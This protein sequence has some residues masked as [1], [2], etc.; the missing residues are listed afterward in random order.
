MSAGAMFT[1]ILIRGILKLFDLMALSIRCW[2]SFTAPSGK[3]TKKYPWPSH[4][5]TSIV[6]FIASTPYTALP[7]VFTSMK[8]R[9]ENIKIRS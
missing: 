6:M 3:P 4:T 7:K 5:F 8:K 2:L 9:I 1:T